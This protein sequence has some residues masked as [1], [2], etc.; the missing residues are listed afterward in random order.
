MSLV[1]ASLGIGFGID[2]VR[3][4]YP[5]SCYSGYGLTG[6]IPVIDIMLNQS[7]AKQTFFKYV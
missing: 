3:V 6:M 2:W 1:D 5:F 7:K 4:A